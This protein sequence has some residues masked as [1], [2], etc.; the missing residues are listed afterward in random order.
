MIKYNLTKLSEPAKCWYEIPINQVKQ[1]FEDERFTGEICHLYNDAE[2]GAESLIQ[3][4][5]Q[6]GDAIF[7]AM[8]NHTPFVAHESDVMNHRELFNIN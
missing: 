1:L 6:L 4:D 2:D 8:E 7:E 5:E 3:T